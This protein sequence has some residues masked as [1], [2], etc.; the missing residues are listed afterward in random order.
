MISGSRSFN[1]ALGLIHLLTLESAS[2][3]PSNILFQARTRAYP[4]S[5]ASTFNGQLN[6]TWP[7]NPALGLIHLLTSSYLGQVNLPCAFN[8]ALGLIHL[9]TPLR[10]SPISSLIALSIPHSVLSIF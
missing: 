5:D 7:F 3:R 4:S 9:L 2:T 1:P 10:Y 8:P 6:Q